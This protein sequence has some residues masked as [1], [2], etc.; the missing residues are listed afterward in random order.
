MRPIRRAG[1]PHCAACDGEFLEI[2]S[3][4]I[5]NIT[6][7]KLNHEINPDPSQQ[8][9]PPPPVRPGSSPPQRMT[10]SRP[11][12]PDHGEAE[13]G[14][15]ASL[16]GGLLGAAGP[17]N[18]TAPSYQSSPPRTMGT[19]TVAGGSGGG[20]RSF[21]FNLPG[22][23]RGQVMFGSFENGATAGFG[24]NAG[25]MGGGHIGP[26]GPNRMGEDDTNGLEQYVTR[27]KN[28]LMK[29]SFPDSVHSRRGGKLDKGI[30]WP[31]RI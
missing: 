15:L 26:F 5:T 7:V 3:N 16:F 12:S 20:G 28:L 11:L 31:A 4:N 25:F 18:L 22:G 1:V 19:G 8:L 23:G 13:P 9:P 14:L 29:A 24:G 21:A 27:F 10:S 6:N 2:V 17:S 30:H